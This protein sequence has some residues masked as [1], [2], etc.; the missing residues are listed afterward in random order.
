MARDSGVSSS[1][2]E[3]S[4]CGVDCSSMSKVRHT[5]RAPRELPCDTSKGQRTSPVRA[6]IFLVF[7]DI[8]GEEASGLLGTLSMKM[9]NVAWNV[10]KATCTSLSRRVVSNAGT[11]PVS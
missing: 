4:C 6:A 2:A 11:R 5:S 3:S 8:Q 7:L 1:C 10:D 9:E